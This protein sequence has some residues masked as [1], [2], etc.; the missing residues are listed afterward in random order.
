MCIKSNLQIFFGRCT[1][2][3]AYCIVKRNCQLQHCNCKNWLRLLQIAWRIVDFETGIIIRKIKHF[4]VNILTCARRCSIS[5]SCCKA[6]TNAVF[7]LLVCSAFS[8]FFTLFVT[9]CSQITDFTP[10]IVNKKRVEWCSFGQYIFF[11]LYSFYLF[12]ISKQV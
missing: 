4:G 5:C 10:K 8:A 3:V 11:Y 9:H 2:N 6:L 7:N 1:Y 12:P